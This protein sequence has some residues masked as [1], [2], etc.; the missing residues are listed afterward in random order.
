MR[1]EPLACAHCFGGSRESYRGPE[2][3][4][5]KRPAVV[6]AGLGGL[7]ATVARGMDGWLRLSRFLRV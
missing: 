7:T 3:S 2:G 6:A 1:P 5:S 4:A